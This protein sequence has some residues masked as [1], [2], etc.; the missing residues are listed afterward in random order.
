MNFSKLKEV[1]D[2]N[3]IPYDVDLLS[4]SGW[5]GGETGM[6][7]IYYSKEDNAIIFRQGDE[8]EKER[9]YNK[10]IYK[11]IY[12]EKDEGVTHK[13]RTPYPFSHHVDKK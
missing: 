4:D 1:L 8:Y 13:P 5:E 7:S 6:G 10:K 11:L 2:K 3:N 9:A 12:D